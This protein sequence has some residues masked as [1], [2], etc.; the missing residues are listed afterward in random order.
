MSVAEYRV[1]VERKEIEM[2]NQI[3]EVIVSEIES[4]LIHETRIVTI[5]EAMAI[6]KGYANSDFY[7]VTAGFIRQE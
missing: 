3:W 1:I 5:D 2:K 6:M 4:G 7:V